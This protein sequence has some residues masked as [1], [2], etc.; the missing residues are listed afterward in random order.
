MDDVPVAF[1]VEDLGTERASN[2]DP[3]EMFIACPLLFPGGRGR[4][5]GGLGRRLAGER[6]R[7]LFILINSEARDKP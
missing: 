7:G 3:E 6:E 4:R 1:M 2:V 5:G